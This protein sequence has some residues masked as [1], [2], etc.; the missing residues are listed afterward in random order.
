MLGFEN[1]ILYKDRLVELDTTDK[2]IMFSNG[3]LP[4]GPMR[5]SGATYN[6]RIAL[7]NYYNLASTRGCGILAEG[8]SMV[9]VGIED[10]DELMVDPCRFVQN[11]SVVVARYGNELTVKTFYEDPV[12]GKVM[13][14]PQNASKHYQP[15][16]ITD[17]ENL[18]VCG[19]VVKIARQPARTCSQVLQ[20]RMREY[21]ADR[22]LDTIFQRTIEAGYMT[23]DFD[24]EAN[25]PLEFIA[26][27]VDL[28]CDELEIA[29]KWDW[30]NKQ[31]GHSGLKQSFYRIKGKMRYSEYFDKV[32]ALIG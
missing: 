4:C 32:K 24:W 23:R 3:S 16:E 12:T 17:K 1:T 2:Y 5:E 20:E 14:F 8:D 27:W 22:N 26:V 15:I 29:D 30:A 18:T 13:L 25:V 7:Q 28:V 19:V 9:D 11:G 31:W 6:E 21:Q 10:G